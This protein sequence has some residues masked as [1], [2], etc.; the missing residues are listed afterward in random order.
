MSQPKPESGADS[1]ITALDKHFINSPPPV[2]TKRSFEVQIKPG[3]SLMKKMCRCIDRLWVDCVH[4]K[5]LNLLQIRV[6][7]NL[8]MHLLN[9]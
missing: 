5:C 1:Q 4:E 6:A 8:N 2:L 9:K 3:Q 7:F